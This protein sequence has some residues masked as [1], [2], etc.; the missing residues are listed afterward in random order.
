MGLLDNDVNFKVS[1]QILGI[2]L[3]HLN[4]SLV[5]KPLQ[6][7]RPKLCKLFYDFYT[8]NFLSTN[9]FLKNDF[10]CLIKIQIVKNSSFKYATFHQKVGHILNSQYFSSRLEVSLND[11][12]N[13]WKIWISYLNECFFR[14]PAAISNDAVPLRIFIVLC[15]FFAS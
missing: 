15:Q 5:W 3:S 9:I 8:S 7:A 1:F 12:W 10:L 2:L 4:S 13:L 6:I 11:S 14:F